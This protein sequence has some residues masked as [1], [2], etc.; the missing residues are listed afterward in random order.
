MPS[1]YELL[2]PIYRMQMGTYLIY[3]NV[4]VNL[5]TPLLTLR[6]H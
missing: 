4:F 2:M 1:N 6:D 5:N 3:I